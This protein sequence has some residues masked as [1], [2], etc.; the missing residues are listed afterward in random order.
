MTENNRIDDELL[1]N[2]S[3]GTG[4]PSQN[5]Q[6]SEVHKLAW[7]SRCK[8]KVPYKEFSGGRYVCQFCGQ[9]LDI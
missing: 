3:G 1:E 9:F 8:T 4:N 6:E 2:V 5:E 7:C